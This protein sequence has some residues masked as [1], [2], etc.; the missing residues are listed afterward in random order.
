MV[1]HCSQQLTFS[2]PQMCFSPAPVL[3]PRVAALHPSRFPWVQRI[4]QRGELSPHLRISLAESLP[5]TTTTLIS[6]FFGENFR[7]YFERAVR[8]LAILY[9]SAKHKVEMTVT[10]QALDQGYSRNT[11]SPADAPAYCGQ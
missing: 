5:T 2:G 3:L 9:K 8:V 7:N 4:F 10:G 6:S 11:F 1:P